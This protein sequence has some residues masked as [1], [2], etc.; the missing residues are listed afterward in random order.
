MKKLIQKIKLIEFIIFLAVLGWFERVLAQA[1]PKVPSIPSIT[2]SKF[3]F[4]SDLG[5]I[6]KKILN[7]VFIAA[8]S[9]FVIMFIIGGVQYL[10]S[11]GN[12]E[13]STKAKKILTDALIGII[14]TIA[15]YAIAVWIITQIGGTLP[16][17]LQ[18]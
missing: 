8:C 10:T 14:I 6:V 16:S 1:A 7:F 2:G 13:A 17:E 12:E 4:P 15:S 5:G 9:A 3:G 18:D 11:A